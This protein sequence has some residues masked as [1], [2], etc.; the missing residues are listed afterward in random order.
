M[1]IQS[2]NGKIVTAPFPD[3]GAQVERKGGLMRLAEPK[4]IPLRV[5]VANL[6][7]KVSAGDLVY[8][9]AADYKQPWASEKWE[10]QLVAGVAPA[11]V[12]LVPIGNVFLTEHV[13]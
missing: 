12:I 2:V 10:L 6:E 8:V 3:L 7:L 1:S 11:Q 13:E 9:K 5:L 4:F